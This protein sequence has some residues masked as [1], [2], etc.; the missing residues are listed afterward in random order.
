MENY[1]VGKSSSTHGEPIIVQVKVTWRKYC[2][3]LTLTQQNP[4]TLN[5]DLEQEQAYETQGS[6]LTKDPQSLDFFTSLF[7]LSFIQMF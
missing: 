3:L 2:S 1:C 7:P 6:S 5:Q 4:H